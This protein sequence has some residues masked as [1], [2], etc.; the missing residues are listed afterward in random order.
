[1]STAVQLPLAAPPHRNRYLFADHYLDTI[2]PGRPQCAAQAPAAEPVRRALA[3]RYAAYM[4]T[5]GEAQVER[6]LIQPV[7]ES[8]GHA[9]DVQVA[10]K[11]PGGNKRPDYVLYRDAA[12]RDANKGRMVDETL[13]QQGAIAVGDAK[14]WDRPLDQKLTG[15][16][17]LFTN[18]NPSYQ[19]AFY[20]RY[21]GVEWGILTNGRLWRLYHRGTAE[22]L[23]HFYEVDLP[24][25]LDDPARIE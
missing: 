13:P 16:G 14:A 11:V 3:G 19:I 8:L 21:S 5:T 24:A 18:K 4:P 17:D 20:M 2:L 10:L 25:V 9:F 1:M 12:A 22:K 6:D 23:D 15:G 7:L